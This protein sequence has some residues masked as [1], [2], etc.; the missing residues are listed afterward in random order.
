RD[1]TLPD[2]RSETVH[3]YGWYMRKYIADIR[4]KKATPILLSLTIRNIWKDGPDGKPHIE[5]DMGYGAELRQL[6]ATEH[7][8]FVDMAT[9]EADRLEAAGPEKTA[10]LFPIDHT[11][12]SA[13]GAELNAQSVAIA[14]RDAHS[15]LAAYLKAR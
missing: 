1:V 3:T 8:A 9:I 12:T 10:L 15:P 2:G 11:H 14:L 5:R 6:A 7:V 13:E 4:A